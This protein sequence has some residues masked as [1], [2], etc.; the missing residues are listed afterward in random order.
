[1]PANDSMSFASAYPCLGPSARLVRTRTTGSV[2]STSC[3]PVPILGG[4]AGR[5]VRTTILRLPIQ[6]N[7]THDPNCALPRTICKDLFATES[8]ER[9]LCMHD[10]AEP[11]LRP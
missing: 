6:R 10:R 1:M 3:S 9:Y 4:P 5:L 8:L 2:K 7:V 11:R